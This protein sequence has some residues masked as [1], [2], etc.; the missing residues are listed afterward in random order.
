MS[1]SLIEDIKH[2]DYNSSP[3]YSLNHSGSESLLLL[4][5]DTLINNNILSLSLPFLTIISGWLSI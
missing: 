5:R 3:K 2:S 4:E 1:D